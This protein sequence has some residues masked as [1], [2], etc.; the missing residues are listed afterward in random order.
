MLIFNRG[1]YVEQ[2]RAIRSSFPAVKR[3]F[4]LMG[5]DK[6]VQILDARYYKNRD[7]ELEALF[8]EAEL[9]VAPRGDDDE[10]DLDG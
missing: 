7:V 4:L 8:H 5:Y 2:A 10:A 9:L 3:I 6:V 1:L